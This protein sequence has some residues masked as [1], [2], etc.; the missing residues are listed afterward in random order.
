LKIIIQL[1]RIA[2][3]LLEAVAKWGTVAA[4]DVDRRTIILDVEL[5]PRCEERRL[6]IDRICSNLSK[7]NFVTRID[8]PGYRTMRPEGWS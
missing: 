8:V 2:P 6:Q 5:S 3:G 1:L 4:V 7:L